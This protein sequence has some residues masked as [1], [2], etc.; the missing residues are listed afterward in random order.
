MPDTRSATRPSPPVVEHEGRLRTI[1]KAPRRP[2]TVA[3]LRHPRI[4][5]ATQNLRPPE[6]RTETG[7]GNQRNTTIK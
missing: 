2:K 4:G 7:G 6:I 3:P 5:V 1:R